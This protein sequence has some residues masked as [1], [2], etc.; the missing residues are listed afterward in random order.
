MKVGL[1]NSTPAEYLGE[2]I[3]TGC[4]CA[5]VRSVV[6]QSVW[7]NDTGTCRVAVK[8]IAPP[9]YPGWKWY[10]SRDYT[11]R[12][13]FYEE[14]EYEGKYEEYGPKRYTN[15]YFRAVSP[16]REKH[17]LLKDA[18]W[19]REYERDYTCT[20]CESRLI[21]SFNA[22]ALEGEHISFA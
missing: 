16:V 21:R 17:L 13:P 12:R 2:M 3:W 9:P 18:S 20:L 6:Y 14:W 7:Q 10:F 22:L 8:T 15:R 5:T 1:F 11:C 4:S 19:N